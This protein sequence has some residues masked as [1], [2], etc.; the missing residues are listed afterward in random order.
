MPKLR[1]G[2]PISVVKPRKLSLSKSNNVPCAYEMLEPET[3]VGT[4]ACVAVADGVF[5]RVV[6][7][8]A[9]PAVLAPPTSVRSSAHTNVRGNPAPAPTGGT[10][11]VL[12]DCTAMYR[13]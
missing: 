2:A 8:R 1:R 11:S 4:A 10:R 12:V 3:V 7:N 6:S 13:D 9:Y 5:Q